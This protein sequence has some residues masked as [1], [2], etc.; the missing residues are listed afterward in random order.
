MK[1]R[2][3]GLAL[4]ASIAL[5]GCGNS[6]G[7]GDSSEPIIVSGKPWTEQ[8]ILPQI[9]GQYIEG[10]TDY[11]VEYEEGLGEVAI[12]TP[13]LEK[14]D[15]D[16]YVEYTGT[17]LQS[18]LGEKLEQGESSEKVLERV[19]AGYE[20]K[21]GVTWLEPLGFENTYT[22]AYTK[23]K[24]YN[25]KTYSDLVEASKSEKMTFGAPHAFYERQGDG[26]DAMVEVYPFKFAGIESLEPNI[27]YE[28][29]KQGDVDVIPAFTTDGRIERFDLATTTDDL[30]F[31]P[32]YDAAPLVRTETLEQ[33]PNLEE[34]LN[35]LAGKISVEDMQKMNAL[36]DIDGKKAEDVAH[37]FLV[38][39]GLIK[40]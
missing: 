39:K 1:K 2:M 10:N 5:V 27:M 33:Y 7:G 13:A 6:N 23:D 28:A 30:G 9:I 12:L 31:F 34:A 40:E 20:E 38:E 22:L 4:L 14:G 11:E 37:D 19:R 18:V 21:F 29:V 35:G 17:G 16:V 24:P 36:V 32:K 15:I 25:A 26:Y 8:F 3:I